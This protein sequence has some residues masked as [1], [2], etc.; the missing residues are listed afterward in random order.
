[1]FKFPSDLGCVKEA[2]KEVLASLEDLKLNASVLFDI[3]L[4]FEEAFINAVKYGNQ[5]DKRL[6]VDVDIVKKEN[7]FEIAVYD[8]GKG[9]DLDSVQ[10]PTQDVNLM[11]LSGRGLFLIKTLMDQVTYE[12]GKTCNC[13]RM[14]KKIR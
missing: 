5:F 12:K 14:V 6:T 11:K 2:S 7:Y 13:L 3:R 8:R 4:C 1:M 9:F 10:N